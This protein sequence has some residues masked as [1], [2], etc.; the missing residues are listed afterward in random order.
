MQRQLLQIADKIPDDIMLTLLKS[1]ARILSREPEPAAKPAPFIRAFARIRDDGT[2]ASQDEDLV[3]DYDSGNEVET[4]NF[5][6][7]TNTEE[8]VYSIG[9]NE[10]QKLASIEEVSENEPANGEIIQNGDEAPEIPENSENID[11]G[12][13][14]EMPKLLTMDE[15]LNESI[16]NQG[17]ATEDDPT[18]A[19][20]DIVENSEENAPQEVIFDEEQILVEEEPVIDQEPIPEEP[21]KVSLDDIQREIEEMQFFL[22]KKGLDGE[23]K[24]KKKVEEE[25]IE[26]NANETDLKNIEDA[27][28]VDVCIKL[29]KNREHKEHKHHHHHKK[30]HHSKYMKS[31][32]YKEEIIDDGPIFDPTVPNT[33]EDFLK[34]KSVHDKQHKKP[35]KGTQAYDVSWQ[36]IMESQ[37]KHYKWDLQPQSIG[38]IVQFFFSRFRHQNFEIT[39]KNVLE[40]MQNIKFNWFANEFGIVAS[41]NQKSTPSNSFLYFFISFIMQIFVAY[42]D[43]IKRSN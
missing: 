22:K 23:K 6:V 43:T 31:E 28:Q 21:P 3:K 37:K 41:R 15:F 24:K 12:I 19:F 10:S 34:V 13:E 36:N 14:L 30:H 39:K 5:K 18:A 20:N 7:T 17:A 1:F 35:K 32:N 16:M 11:E 27:Y 8:V 33:Q 40:Q 42:N 25:K 38:F 26:E 9:E 29:N 2:F 4:F